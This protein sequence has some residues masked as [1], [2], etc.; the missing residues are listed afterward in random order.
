[1]RCPTRSWHRVRPSPCSAG[2][3][4]SL[5]AS[6]T[7]SPASAPTRWDLPAT[8]F[9]DVDR[10]VAET[11]KAFGRIDLLVNCVGSNARYDA[12]DF[13]ETE[14]DRIV[15]LNLKAAFF[16]S[17]RVAREMIRQGKRPT[18]QVAGKILHISP[19]RSQLGIHAGYAAYCASKGGLNPLVKQLA[20]EWAGGGILV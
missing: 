3:R 4:R 19:V 12:E 15:D 13:P 10:C 11:V 1:M 14:W 7:N 9:A 18:R 6:Q 17:Q 5:R 20:T 16:L 2:R 8:R